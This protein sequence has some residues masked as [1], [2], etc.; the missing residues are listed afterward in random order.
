[1]WHSRLG[2]CGL[3]GAPRRGVSATDLAVARGAGVHP[4]GKT[5][6]PC[7]SQR[8]RRRSGDGCGT[9]AG[10]P[11]NRGDW[12]YLRSGDGCRTITNSRT[13]FTSVARESPAS[14]RPHGRTRRRRGC[15]RVPAG[16]GMVRRR[17]AA[18]GEPR[19]CLGIKG[20]ASKQ[21]FAAGLAVTVRT[22]SV[23]YDRLDLNMKNKEMLIVT[24]TRELLRGRFGARRLA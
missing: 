18:T 4:G 13:A 14:R 12:L 20:G 10:S 9:I 5:A 8:G 2:L 7:S 15:W 11:R 3:A 1:M 21:K 22:L 24:D 17:A 6:G 23:K 19:R 16:R